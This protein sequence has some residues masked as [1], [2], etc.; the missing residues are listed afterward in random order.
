TFHRVAVRI[1]FARCVRRF[2]SHVRLRPLPVD[3]GL[4]LRHIRTFRITPK[5][6]RH[7]RH[8]RLV[9]R[10]DPARSVCGGFSHLSSAIGRAR[11]R[12]RGLVVV[13]LAHQHRHRHRRSAFLVRLRHP[14]SPPH[15]G[16]LPPISFA[17]WFV[18]SR[19]LP[20]SR[21]IHARTSRH[22]H[23]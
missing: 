6:I 11:V 5:T 7:R 12:P 22:F 16:R 3:R 15:H 20:L 8:S 4:A 2:K 14:T 23:F 19:S 17:N 9:Y 21:A 18:L 1:V 10:N 13:E